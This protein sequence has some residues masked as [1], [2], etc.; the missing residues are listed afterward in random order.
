[1]SWAFDTDKVNNWAYYNDVFT[2]EEC[3]KIIAHGKKQPIIDAKVGGGDNKEVVDDKIRIT[4]IS[5]I[6]PDPEI[7][8]AYRKLVDATLGLNQQYFNFDLTGFFEK[9]KFTEYYA[10]DGFYKSHMD[11]VFNSVIRKLSV[12]VQLTDP[13]DYEGGELEVFSGPEPEVMIKSRGA[14]IAFPSYILHQVKP[15]TKGQRFSLVGWTLGPN[16]K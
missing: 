14:V 1:M 6:E 3:E 13:K 10:P 2:P 15:V 5:W 4:K 11:K 16:F 12:S 7:T 9:L 8:W